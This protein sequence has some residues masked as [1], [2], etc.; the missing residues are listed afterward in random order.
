MG[1]PSAPIMASYQL[2]DVLQIGVPSTVRVDASPTIPAQ[3]ITLHYTLEGALESG[4]PQPH[5]EYGATDKGDSLSQN[6]TIIPLGEGRHRVIVT[7]AITDNN[8]Q[9]DS[10]SFAIPIVLG[11]YRQGYPLPNRATAG[12]DSEGNP[13]IVLPVQQE[14]IKH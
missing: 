5:F 8:G 6:I 1:K 7:I 10:L 3:R 11:N 12:K 9:T 14:I 4:D 13:I 2:V